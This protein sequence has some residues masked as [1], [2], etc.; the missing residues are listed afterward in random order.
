MLTQRTWDY[1]NLPL[2]VS[3]L[4]AAILCLSLAVLRR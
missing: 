2:T 1:P 4:V 3:I